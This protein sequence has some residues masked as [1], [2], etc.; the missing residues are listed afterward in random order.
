MFYIYLTSLPCQQHTF[1]PLC[2]F[3]DTTIRN[4]NQFH[5]LFNFSISRVGLRLRE[6]ETAGNQRSV[7]LNIL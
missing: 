3:L 4:Y 7:P 5:A 6:E 1:Q 2:L